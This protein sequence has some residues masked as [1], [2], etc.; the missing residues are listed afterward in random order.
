MKKLFIFV[1]E[2]LD[3]K[4]QDSYVK[5]SLEKRGDILYNR[6]VGAMG[7]AGEQKRANDENNSQWQGE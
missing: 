3:V 5:I 1:D 2:A 6:S 4:K 7:N